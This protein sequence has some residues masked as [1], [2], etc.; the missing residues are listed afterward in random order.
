MALAAANE[1]E[2]TPPTLH[3][4]RTNL[5]IQL[6]VIATWQK[7]MYMYFKIFL[8]KLMGMLG[9]VDHR[10]VLVVGLVRSQLSM[11]FCTCNYDI[12]RD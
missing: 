11:F 6:V 4:H 5:Q 2:K 7:Y 8:R 9:G 10:S 3:Q 1:A 12:P